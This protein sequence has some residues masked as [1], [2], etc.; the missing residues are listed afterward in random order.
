MYINSTGE[1]HRVKVVKESGNDA[2]DEAVVGLVNSVVSFGPPPSPLRSRLSNL[3]VEIEWCP[4]E[5][6]KKG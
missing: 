3:G 6:G 5:C 4:I 2:F 1:P